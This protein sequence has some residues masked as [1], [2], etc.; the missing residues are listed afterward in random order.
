MGE[1]RANRQADPPTAEG[2]G[3]VR[4][5]RRARPARPAARRRARGAPSTPGVRRLRMQT[6][7]WPR[8]PRR[9]APRRPTFAS[10]P[11]V[12]PSSLAVR[13]A[14]PGAERSRARTPPGPAAGV[15]ALFRRHSPRI[16]DA[17]SHRPQARG[18]RDLDL[19]A[20]PPL[21]PLGARAPLGHVGV[22]RSRKGWAIAALGAGR[23]AVRAAPLRSVRRRRHRGCRGK[24]LRQ[25][26]R[27]LER[28]AGAGARPLRR[29]HVRGAARGAGFRSR[30]RE[31]PIAAALDGRRESIRGALGAVPDRARRDG[32][33][34][35]AHGP[36]APLL[37]SSTARS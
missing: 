6:P 15:F 36:G 10:L 26:R 30:R 9:R 1:G 2:G 13:F 21:R 24:L 25:A 5:R 18:A 23:A 7:T 12:S 20:V 32:L 29:A 14:G 34:E 17:L 4:S 35:R 33:S 19:P 22:G 3:R 37:P 28:L 27:G 16:H 31:D 8:E 11:A